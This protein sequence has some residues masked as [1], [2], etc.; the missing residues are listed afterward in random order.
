[1]SNVVTLLSRN[2]RMAGA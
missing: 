2:S 1:M